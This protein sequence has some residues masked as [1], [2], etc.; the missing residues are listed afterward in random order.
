MMDDNFFNIYCNKIKI[1]VPKSLV[2]FNNGLGIV[3]MTIQ[4]P[5]NNCREQGVAEYN[6]VGL[7]DENYK[8]LL[9][10]GIE[11]KTIDIF[12][13]GN[14]LLGVRYYR[15]Q[16][17]TIPKSVNICHELNSYF[18]YKLVGGKLKY[19]E[20]IEYDGY[21]VLEDNTLLFYLEDYPETT[22]AYD[23]EIAKNQGTD[24]RRMQ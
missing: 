21:Q 11:N 19:I 1:R 16:N 24:V 12:D 22:L 5:S 17:D 6:M 14:I 8:T 7:V 20:C 15:P 18:H 13:D 4:S 9:Q 10:L 2:E 3:R 23:F